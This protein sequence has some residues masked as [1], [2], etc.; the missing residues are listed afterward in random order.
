M[1]ANFDECWQGDVVFYDGDC[2]MRLEGLTKEEFDSCPENIF[3][4]HEIQSFEGLARRVLDRL[5]FSSNRLESTQRNSDG[6][7]LWLARFTPRGVDGH[8]LRAEYQFRSEEEKPT[9]RR[10]SRRRRS[11]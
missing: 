2:L 7:P 4:V 8:P 11:R 9:R 6:S 1:R 5:K 3:V 10:N